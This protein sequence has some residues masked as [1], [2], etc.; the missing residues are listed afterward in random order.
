MLMPPF[1]GRWLGVAR[2]GRGFGFSDLGRD[3][4]M[5]P[6][7]AGGAACRHAGSTGAPTALGAVNLSLP[8]ISTGGWSRLRCVL[9]R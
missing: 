5:L 3:P 7:D 6:A 1:A 9:V 2:Q 8:R 4:N